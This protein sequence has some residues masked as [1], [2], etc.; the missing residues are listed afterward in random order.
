MDDDLT[1]LEN[2]NLY[3]SGCYVY[4]QQAAVK[5]FFPFEKGD[6]MRFLHG[7]GFYWR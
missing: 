1:H 5:R 2:E 7:E 3:Y 6:A 4:F